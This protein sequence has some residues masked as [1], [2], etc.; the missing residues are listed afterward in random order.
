MYTVERT[1][2]VSV[3]HALLDMPPGHPCNSVHGHNLMITV[4]VES[5]FLSGRGMVIDFGALGALFTHHVADVI[6]HQNLNSVSEL[7]AP[8]RRQPTSEGLARWIL[9]T[10]QGPVRQLEPN[11]RVT[12]VSVRE[13]RDCCA[14]YEV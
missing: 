7:P 9:E 6:D 13:T 14:A 1:F 3:G 12:E 10:L 2:E 8:L 5:P 4:Q 11:A